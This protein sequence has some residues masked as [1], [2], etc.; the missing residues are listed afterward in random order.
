MLNAQ[1]VPSRKTSPAV[2][3]AQRDLFLSPI[4]DLKLAVVDRHLIIT[5]TPSDEIEFGLAHSLGPIIYLIRAQIWSPT[6]WIT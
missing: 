4:N 3:F 5:R 1:F 2:Q 6:F